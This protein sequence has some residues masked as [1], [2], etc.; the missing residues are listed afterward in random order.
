MFSASSVDQCTH[1]FYIVH[2]LGEIAVLPQS[3]EIS[4]KFPQYNFARSKCHE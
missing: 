3:F 1:S 2:D 4:N